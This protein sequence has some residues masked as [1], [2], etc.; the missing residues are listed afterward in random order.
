[1]PNM[2]MGGAQR[3]CLTLVRMLPRYG[4]QVDLYLIE[5][6]GELLAD[7]RQ[8]TTVHVHFAAFQNE[9]GRVGIWGKLN[10]VIALSRVAKSYDV[11]VGG[12]ELWPTFLTFFSALLSKQPVVGWVH[13]ALEPYLAA[14]GSWTTRLLARCVYPR[15]RRIICVSDGAG[16][17]LKAVT[18]ANP[19]N[20]S[21]IYNCIDDAFYKTERTGHVGIALPTLLAVGRCVYQKG[22]D[23]LLE[24]YGELLRRGIPVRLWIV[25]EGVERPR[26][27][28]I[29]AGLGDKGNI[30]F[31]GATTPVPELLAQADVFVSSSRFEGFGLAI[32]EAMAARVLVVATDCESGPSEILG[33]GQFG[34]LVKPNDP[35]MLADALVSVIRNLD[36]AQSTYLHKARERSEAFREEV[37]CRDWARILWDV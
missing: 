2:S 10:Q 19:E 36:S 31:F 25:G 5:G 17:S 24:A 14:H 20:I 1:M 28:K 27:E 3:L 11:I 8:A 18:R 37:F 29:A 9:R 4:I 32:A 33:K 23:V 21:V 35:S 15:I 13:I 34:V 30:K 6:A 7:A 22:Y 26:L 12:L 16:M